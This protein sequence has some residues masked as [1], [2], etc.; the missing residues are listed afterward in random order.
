MR[1]IRLTSVLPLAFR[2]ELE[3]IVFFNPEQDAVARPLVEAVHRYG[4]PCIVEEEGRLRFRVRAFGML[5]TLYALD[6]SESPTTLVG[7]AMFTRDRHANL[8]VLHIAVHE[9]YTSQGRWA[10]A[11]VV[12][13]MIAAVRSAARRTRGI[14]TLRILYP[15]EIRFELRDDA[16]ALACRPRPTGRSQ[17]AVRNAG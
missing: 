10:D 11:G 17:R 6:A 4:V 12:G 13:R 7:V 2:D 3:R 8:S 16:A 15:H 5:Q 1:N 14:R 9:D